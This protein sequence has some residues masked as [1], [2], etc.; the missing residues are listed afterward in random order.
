M[1][2]INDM[3]ANPPE[4]RVT[5]AGISYLHCNSA[6][7]SEVFPDGAP[8]HLVIHN[9]GHGRVTR[10]VRGQRAL[11]EVRPGAVTVVPKGTPVGWWWD[12]PLGCSVLA[13]DD[14]YLAEAAALDSPS[15]GQRPALQFAERDQDP[16]IASIAGM[17]AGFAAQGTAGDPLWTDSVARVL[18]LHLARNY[19]AKEDAALSLQPEASRAVARAKAFIERHYPSDLRIDDI[20][21][22]ACLSPFHFSRLF[23]R[24]TGLSPHQYLIRVRVEEA[25]RLL[26][27]RGG[28]NLSEVAS[29]VGFYDQSHLTRHFRRAFGTTP[30]RVGAG[31]APQRS[32]PGT[33]VRENAVAV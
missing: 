17:M 26:S 28:A 2:G 16:A 15:Q 24:E 11:R 18:A 25:Q 23:K 4:A 31:L 9:T 3:D 29:A 19:A 12:E 33:P 7:D 8:C 30:G 21:E 27:G 13:L 32:W 14:S 1:N 5:D 22:A 6:N 20:A 10:E